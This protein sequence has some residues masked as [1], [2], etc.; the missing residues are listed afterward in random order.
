[1]SSPLPQSPDLDI[2]AFSRIFERRTNS[3]KFLWLQ[4]I[5]AELE[6]SGFDR[7]KLSMRR[8]CIRM[9]ENSRELITRYRLSFGKQDMIGRHLEKCR[10]DGTGDLPIIRI[11]DGVYRE[12][13][14]WVQYR[15]LSE[16]VDL[17]AGMPDQ[18]K[19]AQ[20]RR[21]A[22][23]LFVR[24]HHPPPYHFPSDEEIQL[25]PAWNAYLQ[26]NCAV[27][28]GWLLWH[29]LKYLQGKN[30]SVPA[31]AS[32]IAPALARTPL[33]QQREYWQMVLDQGGLQCIYSGS[34]V[35]ADD[36]ALDHFIPW[37]FVGHNEL[38][39]LTPTSTQINSSKSNSLPST[40]AYLNAFVQT[41]YQGLLVWRKYAKN[42]WRDLIESYGRELRISPESA[43]Q[44]EVRRGYKTL[45]EPLLAIAKNQ[46][47]RSDWVWREITE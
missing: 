47:F 39:N 8:L 29:W 16:F 44:D 2:G 45:L 21:T 26:K 28:K 20:I 18:K 6:E 37:D 43:G 35:S 32:K 36:F 24:D 19:N 9:L 12:L 40:S 38:W 27:V 15:T 23:Q 3:Y 46:G 10:E 17:P 11:P 14:R 22:N 42:R 13:T 31:I 41:Q 1:M 30:P 34:A 33:K 5:L 25:H 7:Q 4:A